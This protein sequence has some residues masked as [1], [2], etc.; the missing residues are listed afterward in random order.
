LWSSYHGKW[1]GKKWSDVGASNV[2][3]S[4]YS[5][6]SSTPTPAA[7]AMF[8]GAWTTFQQNLVQPLVPCVL[9]APLVSVSGKYGARGVV[10]GAY[11][12][13][14][15]QIGEAYAGV[16][17]LVIGSN[18]YFI[19]PAARTRRVPDRLRYSGIAIEIPAA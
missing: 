10:P 13:E 3:L 16:T 4:Q 7:G 6:G 19:F 5:F 14:T 1:I 18:R 12:V 9:Y 2:A 17:P 11:Y 8:H 15:K